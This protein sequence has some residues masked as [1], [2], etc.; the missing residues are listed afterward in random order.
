V[1][2]L[3]R[4]IEEDEKLTIEEAALAVSALAALGDREHENAFSSL[5]A[6]AERATRQQRRPREAS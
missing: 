4:L 5:L 1:R 3:R 6:L 2:W